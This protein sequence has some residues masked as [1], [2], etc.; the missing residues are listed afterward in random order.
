MD[1]PYAYSIIIGENDCD[2]VDRVQIALKND[3]VP[4]G[5]VYL[6]KDG[7]PCQPIVKHGPQVLNE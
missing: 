4:Y 5:N 3:W 6:N 2:L 1:T 7:C